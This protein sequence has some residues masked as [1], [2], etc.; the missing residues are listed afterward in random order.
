MKQLERNHQRTNNEANQFVCLDVLTCI[1]LVLVDI[2]HPIVGR[3]IINIKKNN[4]QKNKQKKRKIT[5][6]K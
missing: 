1:V 4:T 5:K 2:P 3:Q 6:D